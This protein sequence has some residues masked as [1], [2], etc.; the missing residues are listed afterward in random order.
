M[1]GNVGLESQDSPFNSSIFSLASVQPY[2]I[3]G[4]N[5]SYPTPVSDSNV[6][7]ASIFL[8]SIALSLVDGSTTTFTNLE[9]SPLHR[10]LISA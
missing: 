6:T 3:I 8:S 9:K 7:F 4:S 10:E 5:S 2:L 1:K